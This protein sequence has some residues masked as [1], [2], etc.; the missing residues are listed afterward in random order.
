[1]NP[2]RIVL[3]KDGV[4]NRMIMYALELNGC[5]VS[6]YDDV[7]WP[8]PG[9]YDIVAACNKLLAGQWTVDHEEFWS[10][11]TRRHWA[12][13]PVSDEFDWLLRA[14]CDLVGSKNVAFLTKPLPSDADSDAGKREW[15][16]RYAPAFQ[17]R[18]FIGADKSFWAYPD[19]LLIDDC[20]D[21]CESFVKAGGQALLVPRP[22][23]SRHLEDTAEVLIDFFSRYQVRPHVAARLQ[24]VGLVPRNSFLA[25]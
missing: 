8:L 5:P 14:C 17:S 25:L 2:R 23:N 20:D 24:G 6:R 4:C 3:D 12:T 15:F 19:T 16:K 9:N 10:Q 18:A 11:V 13:C 7:G 21:N 1:M 22:W